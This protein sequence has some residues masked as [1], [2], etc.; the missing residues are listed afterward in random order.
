VLAE[1]LEKLRAEYATAGR[2]ELFDALEPHSSGSRPLPH[3][4]ELAGRWG[5]TEP[6]LRMMVAR[7]RRRYGELLRLEVSHTVATTAEIDHELQELMA[8]LMLKA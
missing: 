1:A 6:T 2:A 4:R 8:A 7:L 3:Y 5:L